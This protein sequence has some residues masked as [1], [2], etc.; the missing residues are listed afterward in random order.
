MKM[1][2]TPP[3]VIR[4]WTILILMVF[5]VQASYAQDTTAFSLKQAQ[6]Y[7]LENSYQSKNAALDIEKA[8]R[9]RKKRE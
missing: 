7:A 3:F 8:E 4:H 5:V 6:E 1:N 2:K 9:K